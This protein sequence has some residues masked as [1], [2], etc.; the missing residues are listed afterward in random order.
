MWTVRS[1]TQAKVAAV[2]TARGRITA[3]TYWITSTHVGYSMYGLTDM[4]PKNSPFSC[5]IWARP[6]KLLICPSQDNTQKQ[7]LDW[8]AILKQ[9]KD[10]TDRQTH[11]PRYVCSNRPH[12]RIARMHAISL[13]MSVN[14]Q[15]IDTNRFSKKT[16]LS[17]TTFLSNTA[18]HEHAQLDVLYT[19]ELVRTWTQIWQ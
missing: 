6:N 1:Q 11:R 18:D 9:W 4:Q 10:V 19:S 17:N 5:V 16:D 3:A 14:S 13:I 2:L 7:H 12:L 15:L 8:S